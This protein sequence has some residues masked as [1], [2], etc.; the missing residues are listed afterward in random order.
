MGPDGRYAEAGALVS[1]GENFA[2]LYRRAGFLVDKILRGAKPADIPV[3]R[4]M[5]F[6]L[7][8]NQKTAAALGVTVP[9]SV[10]LHADRTFK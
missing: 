8:V 1:Y 4:P 10:L 7:M 3:E 6:E 9:E 5:I 2:T